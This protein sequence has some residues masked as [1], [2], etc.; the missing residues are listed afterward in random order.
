MQRWDNKG[1]LLLLTLVVMPLGVWGSEVARN[2]G[3]DEPMDDKRA[4]QKMKMAA[5]AGSAKA[6]YRLGFMY[7]NGQGV[8]RDEAEA[9]K[10][11][12]KLAEKG[13]ASAQYHLGV[14]HHNGQGVRR[15]IAEALKWFRKSAEQ[16]IAEAQAMLA[17]MYLK[18]QGVAQDYVRSR[19]W[20]H[21]AVAAGHKTA[22]TASD[23]I[24]TIMTPEQ[25]AES[26]RL[27][28]EWSRKYKPHATVDNRRREPGIFWDKSS[29]VPYR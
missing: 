10:W 9:A 2:A 15:N 25:I 8:Q 13:R 18:G 6:Q 4:V 20:L 26:Q 1:L 17:V 11:F 29:E 23:Y 16:G 3:T 7:L 24:E 22:R 19:M 21:I 12:R 27:V 5:E 14:M 28:H